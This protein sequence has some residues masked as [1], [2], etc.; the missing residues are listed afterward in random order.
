MAPAAGADGVVWLAINAKYSHTSLA[1]RYLREAVP[2]SRILEITINDYLLPTLGAVYEMHPRVLGIACYIW[3]IERVKELLQ[4]LPKALPDCT[5]LCGGPEVS[6]ETG[7]FMKAFPMVD[8][9][10]RGEGEEAIAALC[11]RLRVGESGAGIP[12][13]AWRGP[14]GT[15]HEG[16]AVVVPGR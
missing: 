6:Y 9:V 8:Y 10:V 14:D 7:T 2:G 11:E 1:V 12:S 5:I 15:V 3:N 13:V 4:L 16:A